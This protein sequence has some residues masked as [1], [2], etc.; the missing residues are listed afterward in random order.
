VRVERVLDRDVDGA[1]QVQGVDLGRVARERRREEELLALRAATGRERLAQ[2]WK[3]VEKPRWGGEWTYGS[4]ASLVEVARDPPG[5][6]LGVPQRRRERVG[7]LEG[8]LA[9]LGLAL[10]PAARRV[11]IV[12]LVGECG[13]REGRL[14]RRE[15]GREP[16]VERLGKEPVGLVDD[17]RAES[18]SQ[19]MIGTDNGG[20]GGE[21]HEEAQVLEREALG[22]L[23]VVD[24]PT[25]RRDEDVDLALAALA[26]P[27][28]RSTS[29]P[30]GA[31]A[32]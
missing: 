10:P 7:L 32:R 22:R 6:A 4:V 14:E 24:E 19:L 30:C 16:V 17:L 2:T 5:L 31:R 13:G 21:T 26:V 20:E 29:Q 11:H 12:L 25:R 9:H 1:V 23:E 18:Q 15:D 3:T 8:A 27:A 28:G